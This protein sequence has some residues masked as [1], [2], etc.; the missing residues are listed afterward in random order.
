[1]SGLA[2]SLLG[3]F[4]VARDGE[5]ATGF[6]S[7]TARALLAYLALHAGVPCPRETLAG[8]LWPERPDAQALRIAVEDRLWLSLVETLPGL[9]LLWADMGQVGRAVEMYA[10]AAREPYV[11]KERGR[12][13]DLWATA[14]ELLA[15][16]GG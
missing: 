8:L 13:R 15:E 16:L 11:A 3:P 2:I 14:E 7:A 10:L 6:Q 9:A 5:P 1:M 4:Q 12:A